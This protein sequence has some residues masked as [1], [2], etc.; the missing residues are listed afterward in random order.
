[1]MDSNDLVK[2][3]Q[4]LRDDGPQRFGDTQIEWDRSQLTDAEFYERSV[5]VACQTFSS[6][7]N[8]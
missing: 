2:E 7:V 4:D 5:L 3:L 8:R 6:V 1:M